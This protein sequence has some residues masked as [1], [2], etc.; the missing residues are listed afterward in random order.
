MWI[1]DCRLR[2][3]N[4]AG[5]RGP[6]SAICRR[7]SVRDYRRAGPHPESG[8]IA[9]LAA[10]L[11]RH[12][13]NIDAVIQERGWDKHHLPFVITLEPAPEASIQAALRQ[14]EGLAFLREPPLDL[15]IEPFATRAG[16]ASPTSPGA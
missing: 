13:I 3:G 15:P 8:I 14:M 2:I 11:A 4:A 9:A 1:A 6:L 12:N 16:P 7:G 10:I 5:G